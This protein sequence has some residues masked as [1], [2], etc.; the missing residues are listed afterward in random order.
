MQMAL[1]SDQLICL[2]DTIYSDSEMYARPYG[3][4]AMRNFLVGLSCYSKEAGHPS[5]RLICPYGMICPC[6]R[7][8]V[9]QTSQHLKQRIQKHFSTISLASRDK[10]QGKKLTAVAEHSIQVNMEVSRLWVW[11]GSLEMGGVVI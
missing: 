2:F 1:K 10:N 8:Y 4:Y 5:N 11:S 7:L 9:G 6:A 3:G